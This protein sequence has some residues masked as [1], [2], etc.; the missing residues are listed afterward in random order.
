MA[1]L[2]FDKQVVAD[3]VDDVA[4]EL[5]LQRVARLAQV[6]LEGGVE[7]ALGEEADARPVPGTLWSAWHVV[8]VVGYLGHWA[9]GK[10]SRQGSKGRQE[11]LSKDAKNAKKN[12]TSLGN[13]ERDGAFADGFDGE[14]EGFADVVGF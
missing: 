14:G 12:K 5:D 10:S 6:L 3:E 1:G 8:F 9:Q 11:D 2:D 7:G 4:A 13:H